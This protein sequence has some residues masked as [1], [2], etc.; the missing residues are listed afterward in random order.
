M[1][2]GVARTSPFPPP[3]KKNKN[4]PSNKRRNGWM[5]PPTETTEDNRNGPF[6]TAGSGAE[7]MR[8]TPRQPPTGE[9]ASETKPTPPTPE[10]A[11]ASPEVSERSLARNYTGRFVGRFPSVL[12]SQP[13][14]NNS[15]RTAL[16]F[17][18]FA[19][20]GRFL[21]SY[22]LTPQFRSSSPR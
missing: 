7:R 1:P 11:L 16:Q 2:R 20:S 3:P 22:A 4:E 10:A 9:A 19:Y 17:A 14:A 13:L 8:R 21:I 15:L 18:S 12:H 5:D 6:K